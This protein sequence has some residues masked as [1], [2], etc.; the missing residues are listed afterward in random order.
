[1]LRRDRIVSITGFAVSFV[2]AFSELEVVEL[3]EV[4][5][6]I[7]D[8]NITKSCFILLCLIV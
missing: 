4:A 3:Q 5:T 7:A 1:M 2:G 8:T 6:I